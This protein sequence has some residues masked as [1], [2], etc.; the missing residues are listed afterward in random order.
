M[1]DQSDA[2][3]LSG[4]HFGQGYSC[5][6]ISLDNVRCN[7]SEM[8][9]LEC[10]RNALFIH[11]C[12][13]GEDAGVRCTGD[14]DSSL[15][16][17]SIT[18]VS[19]ND[20]RLISAHGINL[21]TVLITWEWQN[22]NN[23]NIKIRNQPNSFQIECF[24]DQ[25]RIG[26][27]VNST[28]FS[29]ELLG[30]LPSTTYNCCVSA[31]YGSY[32]AGGVCTGTATIR[33]PTSQPSEPPVMQLS[34]NPTVML[35]NIS[36]IKSSETPVMLPSGSPT[37]KPE[38]IEIQCETQASNSRASS[39]ADTIGGVLGFIIAILLILLAVLGAALVYLLRPKFLRNVLP[40]V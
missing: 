31:L 7:G 16:S 11:N 36:T 30:L 23:N 6:L 34:E 18:N 19:I 4:A 25:H 22:N 8:T 2:E 1:H 14:V 40:K 38:K 37:V 12:N 21:Y 33:P 5:Q 28:T 9:L 27:S 26:M 24:S 32:T 3:A 15:L 39:S 13:H 20:T 10:Q 29:V 35:G 17:N